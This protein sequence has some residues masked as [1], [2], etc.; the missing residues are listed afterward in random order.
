MR[1]LYRSVLHFSDFDFGRMCFKLHPRVEEISKEEF[2]DAEEAVI[3]YEDEEDEVESDSGQA[4]PELIYVLLE[5]VSVY[6][7]ETE[8]GLWFLNKALDFLGE[9]KL[10]DETWWQL[11]LSQKKEV[12]EILLKVDFVNEIEQEGKSDERVKAIADIATIIGAKKDE[13]ATA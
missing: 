7:F 5:H 9:D 13:S 3:N 12:F 2:N 8:R 6:H 11:S 4:D 10:L 1:Y